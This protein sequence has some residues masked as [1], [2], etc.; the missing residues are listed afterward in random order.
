MSAL[1]N[2][3]TVC[4][5]TMQSYSRQVCILWISAGAGEEG[6]QCVALCKRLEWVHPDQ[7]LSSV[8]TKSAALLAPPA[9]LEDVM[10]FVGLA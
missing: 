7:R 1:L 10:H 9:N 3:H 5:A 6:T 4:H 2:F 8:C